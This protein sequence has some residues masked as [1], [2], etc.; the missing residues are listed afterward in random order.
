[1]MLIW[2]A[3]ISAFINQC[4]KRLSGED[5]SGMGCVALT[6]RLYLA[7]IHEYYRACYQ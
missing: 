1:M 4:S 6:Y 5:V 2:Y 7:H 3:D